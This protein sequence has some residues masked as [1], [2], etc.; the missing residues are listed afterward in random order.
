[1]TNILEDNPLDPKYNVIKDNIF[2]NVGKNIE[3][4]SLIS[5]GSTITENEIREMNTIE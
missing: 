4:N 3:I 5:A 2:Q 1:M